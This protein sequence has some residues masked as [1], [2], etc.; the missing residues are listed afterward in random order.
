MKTLLVQKHVNT[1][2]LTPYLDLAKAR[3]VELVCFGELATSGCLYTT[4]EVPDFKAIQA[5]FSKHDFRVMAGFP[6]L[7]TDGLFNSYGYFHKDKYQIYKKIN[8]FPGMN[9]TTVYSPGKQAG[10]FE[11][12]FG[13]V[14]SAICYDLRFPDIFE[15]LKKEKVPIIFLPAAWPNVRIHDWKR[16]IVERAQSTGAMIVAVN[17]VGDDGTNVFGGSSMIVAG[18]G[19]ILAHADE[20]SE[21]T[22]EFN[23]HI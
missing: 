18:D 10:I 1:S 16:L 2:D 17:A 5:Q 8:L 7:S 12:D 4:R 9:E 15:N 20:T 13:R 14:G 6:Y 23:L 3:K 21:T 22:L 19:T 11:T